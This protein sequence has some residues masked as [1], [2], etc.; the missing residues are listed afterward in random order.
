MKDEMLQNALNHAESLKTGL[1]KG[2]ITKDECEAMLEVLKELKLNGDE[3]DVSDKGECIEKVFLDFEQCATE[4]KRILQE[5]LTLISEGRVPAQESVR[6]LD[7]S[8]VTLQNKYNSIYQSALSQLEPDEMPSA[9]SSADLYVE[10][11]RNS[12]TL[13][14]KKQLEEAKT[15]LIRFLAVRSKVIVY[16]NA[17]A[18]Y[19]GNAT[20]LLDSLRSGFDMETLEER[21][22]GP[23]AFLTALEYHDKDSDE[24]IALC[25]AVDSL[26]DS[27]VGK[28]IVAGKYYI[29]TDA[30]SKII[31]KMSTDV[32]NSVPEA[33]ESEAPNGSEP[34][35]ADE[36][37]EQNAVGSIVVPEENEIQSGSN[38][39]EDT[40]SVDKQVE[41]IHPINPIP[42]AKLPSEQK[43]RDLI[44][45]TGGIFVF[46]VD[47]LVFSG[48]MDENRVFDAF[49]KLSK[50][51]TRE[52]CIEALALIERKGFLCTYS[53]KGRNILC[54]TKLMESCLEKSSLSSLL[55]RL[56]S[57]KKI[58]KMTFT[59]A[60]DVPLD[61]FT[62]HLDMA[63]LCAY[64]A[65]MLYN[66]KESADKLETLSWN[67]E[68]NYFL[69]DLVQDDGSKLPLRIVSFDG[70][71][72]CVP[73]DGE[74]VFC[75]TD[76]LPDMSKTDDP[77]HYCLTGEGLFCWTGEEWKAITHI[78]TSQ[79]EDLPLK[80]S[81]GDD[82]PV[83]DDLTPDEDS[84]SISEE[85][86]EETSAPEV[87]ESEIQ[88]T[89]SS[90]QEEHP[91]GLWL[92]DLREDTTN[93]QEVT[94][95]E[96]AGLSSAET[97]KRLLAAANG[98]TPSDESM[99]A[100]VHQLL[101]EGIRSNNVH[102]CH[103]Q[104]VEA[105][106]LA[107]LL[108]SC[109]AF[110]LC[111]NIY[112]QLHAAVPF[113]REVG[114]N[115]GA[116]LT[117]IFADETE[118]TPVTK[119]C[120]YIH[121]MLFPAHAHDHTFTAL[122]NSA[123]SNYESNFPGLEVLK[124]LYHKAM[125]GL[126]TVPTAFSPANLAALSDSK[127]RQ[128]RMSK[129]RAR[130]KELLTPPSVKFMINGVPELI[131]ICFGPQTDLYNALEI[132][133]NNDEEM[134]ELAVNEFANFSKD[135]EI[136]QA[137]LEG[138]LDNRWSV[139]AQ[140]YT[141]RRMG[142][143]YNA[144]KH[145]LHAL[146]ERVNILRD[147][148][149]ETDNEAAPDVER[150]RNIR[151]E[152]LRIA[153]EAMSEIDAAPHTIESGIIKASLELIRAKLQN[154]GAGVDF[155]TMFR[156]GALVIDQGELVLND[157]LNEIKFAEPWRMM[158]RHI[159]CTEYDLERVY[160][161]ILAAEPDSDLYDNIGQLA[162]V[163][164]LIGADPNEYELTDESLRDAVN[165]ADLQA[166]NFREKLEIS[167][168]YNRISEK[169]RERLA[170]LADPESSDLQKFFYDHKAFGCWR[171]FLNALR[172]QIRETAQHSMHDVR[173]QLEQAKPM[174]KPDEESPL[175]TEAERLIVQE[176]N[177][178]VA[179]D[180]IHR[181]RNGERN[182]PFET[183]DGATSHYLDFISDQVFTGLY[184]YC[185]RRK[186]TPLPRLVEQYLDKNKPD[187]WTN[188]HFDDAERFI[189]KW[190]TGK[191]AV[192]PQRIQEFFQL[193]G[194]TVF[195]C[196]KTIRANEVC[197]TLTVKRSEQNQAD[198]RHPISIFGT[199][200]KPQIEVVC[201]FGK[202][203]A[204]QLIDD[205]CRLGITG[206]FVVLLDA[207]LSQMDRR[208]MAQYFFTQKNVG[209][210]SFLVIDRVLALYLTL[211]S[212]NER[213]PAMLQ[214]TLP[215]TIY[216][217][218][219]NG[220]GST[221]DEMFFG[222][223]NELASIRDMTGT[224]IVYGG[225]QLGKTALL[226][227]AKHLDN[228]PDRKEF[229]VM[230]SFKGCR[231][232]RAFLD[233]LVFACNET[234]TKSGIQLR[235]CSD[236]RDFCSQV[237]RLIDEDHIATLRLLL[238]EMDDF[239]DSISATS[240]SEILPL[241]ELQRGS[242]R[243]FKFV[244]AGLHNVCRAKNATR[245]NGL[246]GQ[247]GAP[248]C[249]KPLTAADARNLLVRPLRYLGFRVSNESHVDTILTNTNYY[250]GIIQFFGYTLVQTLASQYTQY[251]DAVRGNPPFEL[252]DDQ[253]ASIMNSRDLNNNIK[254]RLRWTL[255]MDARYY[256][257]AR[258]ITVL[259][260]LSSNDY[261]T[262]SNGF[263]VD[264][265]REVATDLFDIHCLSSLSEKETIALL[266]EMEEMGI[267]SRP[268]SDGNRYLLRRR[269][270][271]DVIGTSL[272]VVEHDIELYNEEVENDD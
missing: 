126:K 153:E 6:D 242:N 93:E 20:D 19:Q 265:I 209:Q 199:Q 159:A 134:R 232:E 245:N 61:Q 248:L 43:L 91:D 35:I 240:Y 131:D 174:L 83:S 150:L 7:E 139:A 230:T 264:S 205:A 52:Q 2:S 80:D 207:N 267:L 269:S 142:I 40:D 82:E 268:G 77:L 63:D 114:T 107:K 38:I 41:Y 39:P 110:P 116:A 62:Q 179:E 32:T 218:F 172:A 215:Y 163:G 109:E 233:T 133:S 17:L 213:L 13:R 244:L 130:A 225:R 21:V 183:N 211:Q 271:I 237:R 166:Q 149:E 157:A 3:V 200:M 219:T 84:P 119:L 30:E 137:S 175:L 79:R 74:G 104:L 106:V 55:K 178:A 203:T 141:S 129:I 127:I 144:R 34:R 194:L 262:I 56:N 18:P 185:E 210:A 217:P 204:K 48:L 136:D 177:F 266:D 125:E 44:I 15:C 227:R 31:E 36:S 251:Y 103:D 64:I 196:T 167:Y 76:E 86:E 122:Y 81:G 180:Y 33:P 221:A 235:P 23:R 10:A 229:A 170:L 29:D 176:Q 115:T 171:G 228:N 97:A 112:Y 69:A 222:R 53:Y 85:D 5:M 214:C 37:A 216:Q 138:L 152:I 117:G 58:G 201:L 95:D 154:T 113:F 206:T 98:S 1:E 22:A 184:S 247:L 198:Y 249:V 124:S 143:K 156:S 118:Y 11:V 187:G 226:E 66:D 186:D 272:E 75:C 181:F 68:Q 73:A 16:S 47:E 9:D 59:G 146:E 120:A 224:S 147:W 99:A 70:F 65:D 87:P 189:E 212:N 231:G 243:R 256:M 252:H 89:H 255:E 14:Y 71:A 46:L 121:G 90:N 96:S 208:T 135:G 241:I 100:L 192:N 257:L 254:E 54:F 202:R 108:S 51:L 49:S 92:D 151:V 132:V 161:D 160:A 164:R 128:E 191:Q 253:L 111:R 27:R 25:E 28:G 101:K 72:E 223:V 140:K 220:S 78:E 155:S 4:T 168:A 123:F 158:L 260:H 94:V 250:P 102:N 50:P 261:A 259:Y 162:A 26:L 270:F 246:F 197:C 238:D 145:L 263:D 193:L 182:L 57:Q 165:S 8:I 258:C 105:I 42:S 12:K 190:P 88:T 24:G 239:L 60:Q 234:L 236:I 169:E 67:K 188:R 173:S 195:A 45:R 148:L